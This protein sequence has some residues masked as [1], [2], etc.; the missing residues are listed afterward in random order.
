[1]VPDG[2]PGRARAAVLTTPAPAGRGRG[3]LLSPSTEPEGPGDWGANT[4]RTGA[5]RQTPASFS[6][7]P[8]R[9]GT[10][11]RSS[12]PRAYIFGHPRCKRRSG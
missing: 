6:L 12:G 10:L 3:S 8:R 11:R 5:L 7:S 4:R 2:P 1:M 9:P